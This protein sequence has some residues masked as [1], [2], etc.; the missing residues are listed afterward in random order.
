M[1]ADDG[2]PVGAK[3]PRV[4]SGSLGSQQLLEN[5]QDAWALDMMLADGASR[6]QLREQRVQGTPDDL[7]SVT[8]GEDE[9]EVPHTQWYEE[10]KEVQEA[11]PEDKGQE[12]PPMT[13]ADTKQEDVEELNRLAPPL[14][15][16][17]VARHRRRQVTGQRLSWPSNSNFKL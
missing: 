11:P 8:D 14:R 7:E 9:N 13:S 2:G 4:Y 5:T 17:L 16:S 10:A 3:A 1:A 6:V 12:A 15:T